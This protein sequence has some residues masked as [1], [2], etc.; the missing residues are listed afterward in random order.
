MRYIYLG[1]RAGVD[2]DDDAR[3]RRRDQNGDVRA[4]LISGDESEASAVRA[5]LGIKCEMSEEDY[6]TCFRRFTLYF[7]FSPH[8]FSPRQA[9]RVITQRAPFISSKLQFELGRHS[10]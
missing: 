3:E 6:G 1:K 10:L 9:G 5:R 7:F 2:D 4:H 8:L